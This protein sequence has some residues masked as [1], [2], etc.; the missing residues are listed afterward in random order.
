MLP[1][2]VTVYTNL[3]TISTLC[4]LFRRSELTVL[5]WR[6][7][8]GLPYVRIPGDSRDSVRYDLDAVKEWAVQ[9]GKEIFP[10]D[11]TEGEDNAP[12]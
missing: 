10:E 9:S 2:N 4:T 12:A 8:K 11:I 3:A 1:E 7:H 6:R 5:S